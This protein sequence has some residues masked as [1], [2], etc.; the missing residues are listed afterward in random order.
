MA[1]VVPP[2][3]E[4]ADRAACDTLK[5]ESGPRGVC[6][7]DTVGRH[8]AERIPVTD[9][10]ALTDGGDELEASLIVLE[11]TGRLRTAGS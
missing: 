3:T 6:E 7:P 9:G 11:R 8:E 2:G 4:V 5:S 1:D 10:T